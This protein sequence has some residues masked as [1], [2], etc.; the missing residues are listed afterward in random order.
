[1]DRLILH[2]EIFG[3]MTTFIG[4]GGVPNH[5]RII[6]RQTRATG[7]P[8]SAEEIRRLM[9]EELGFEELKNNYGIGYEES[10]AFIRDEAAVFDLRP[11]KVLV[12]DEGVHVVFDS[13]PVRIT[14]E[15]RDHFP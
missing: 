15:N 1:M 6:I 9:I 7:R 10:L 4:I 14:D 3:E 5:R 2:D 11:A 8:A 13:I 12:T